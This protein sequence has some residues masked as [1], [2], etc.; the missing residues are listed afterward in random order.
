VI[1]SAFS[2]ETG[3]PEEWKHT[4]DVLGKIEAYLAQYSLNSDEDIERVIGHTLIY[5][6]YDDRLIIRVR[7]ALTLINKY[8]MQ[9]LPVEEDRKYYAKSLIAIDTYISLTNEVNGFEE[10]DEI[11]SDEIFDWC[12]QQIYRYSENKKFKKITFEALKEIAREWIDGKSYREIQ[13]KCDNEEFYLLTNTHKKISLD[14]VSN[15]C[16]NGFGY[17]S[18]IILN[19]AY[20]M[21]MQ[22]GDEYTDLAD[23]IAQYALQLKYGLSENNAICMYEM[24]INDRSVARMLIEGLQK[25]LNKKELIMLLKGQREEKL[26]LLKSYPAYFSNKF[27]EVIG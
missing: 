25:E 13:E 27:N 4:K 24:G 15:I 17:S 9:K 8:V 3:W 16:D 14:D 12:I 1:S 26:K 7:K 18:T 20:E 10:P 22:M 5:Q 21:V 23:E 19:A 11:G 2:D 6:L